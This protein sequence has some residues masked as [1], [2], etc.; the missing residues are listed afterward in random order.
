MICDDAGPGY[1]LTRKW[2]TSPINTNLP[3]NKILV[4]DNRISGNDYDLL[5]EIIR[6]NSHTIIF[7]VGDGMAE[8]INND[9]IQYLL[10]IQPTKKI[11]FYSTYAEDY[12]Q[13]VLKQK[14]GPEKV[15]TIPYAYNR[16]NEREINFENRKNRILVSG[17]LASASYPL[18]W[19]FHINTYHKF[20][21]YRKV[22]YLKHPGYAD[23]GQK[24]H[25]KI[26]GDQYL[27]YLADFRFML[28]TPSKFDYELLKFRECAYAGCCLVGELPSSINISKNL[29]PGLITFDSPIKGQVNLLLT[30]GQDNLLQS[31]HCYREWFRTNRDPKKLNRILL[32]KIGEIKS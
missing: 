32:T 26:I 28:V 22:K 14:H 8:A 30:T 19:Y 13:S 29:L 18:R 9:N 1:A 27:N 25:H 3:N 12:V 2:D 20:W 7:R 11:F 17:S 31:V 23:I 16:D 24:Q 21:A 5:N 10:S 15:F 4:V 6:M